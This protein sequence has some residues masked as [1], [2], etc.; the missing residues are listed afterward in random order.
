MPAREAPA[1]LVT[2]TGS[3]DRV[4][5][6]GALSQAMLRVLER[7][8]RASTGS[9]CRGSISEQLWANGVEFFRRVS[10]VA[11]NV[12]EYWLEATERI[13]D[14]LDGTVEQKL[15]RAV[16]LLRDEAYQW[17]LTVRD[18]TQADRLIRDFFKAAFQG[19]YI[20]ESY[21]DAQRK[22]FLNL[23]QENKTVAEYEAEFLLLSRYARG[24]VATEYE[25]CV[26]FE[27]GVWDEFRVLI[28]SQR[29][30]DFA[31]LV[32]KEKI[33]EDVKCSEH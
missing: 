31:A 2:E 11:P 7:V 32:E 33:A 18:G 22:E 30:R 19:K 28:A 21:M 14:H 27:N 23:T 6:V 3:H 1:S 4:A 26:H 25:R 29:E 17:W 8:A 13:R 10:S 16:S 9:V 20:G 12:E 15:K 24:I 5:R